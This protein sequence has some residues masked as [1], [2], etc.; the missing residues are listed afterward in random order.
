MQKLIGTIKWV[1]SL[2][3]I[4]NEDPLFT[5]LKGNL[6]LYSLRH[7]TPEARNALNE[8]SQVIRTRQAH[9]MDPLLPFLVAIVGKGAQPYALI[10]QWDDKLPDP[11][12]ILEWVSFLTSQ[13]R[14][15]LHSLK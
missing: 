13:G 12:L 8:V 15:S 10:L 4:S 2:L 5:L 6:A 9:W 1:R 3:G 14:Q 7:L 11:L